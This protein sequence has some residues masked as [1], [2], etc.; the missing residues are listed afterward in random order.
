MNN[1]TH[2]IQTMPKVELHLHLEGAF[3]F[4]FLFDLIEK[5]GGDPTVKTVQDLEKRF[6][7]RDFPHFIQTWIWKNRFFRETADFENSTYFTLKNLHEQNVIYVEA[8]YSP[9]DFLT[10]GLAIEAITEATLAAIK[11]AKEDFGIECVLI[12]DIN[13][14]LGWE[15]GIDRL[16]QVLP[17][18]EQGVIGIG[19]GGSEQKFP[20]EPFQ[21]VYKIARDSGLHVVAHAGEAAG[22]KSVWGAIEKLRVQRIGHGVRSVEDP[23]LVDRLRE[24][25]IPLE[26]CPVS[27]LKTGVF[28]SLEQHP[29]KYFFENGLFVT[30]NSDDPAM[31]GTTITEEFLLLHEQ[32]NFSLDNIKKLALNGARASFLPEKEK[33]ELLDRMKEYWNR[34]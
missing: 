22:P 31:F 21:N 13:R 29:I 7:F 34:V 20:P 4:E 23:K 30:I 17:Y 25:Q 26:V 14:D 3:T 12:A 33:A 15:T 18:R 28:P 9:W 2:I 8:F 32:L 6:V 16:K 11:R 19:L 1:A 27:N 5:Y 10:S 24:K